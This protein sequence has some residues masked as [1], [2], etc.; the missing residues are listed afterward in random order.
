MA[1]FV[2]SENVVSYLLEHGADVNSRTQRGE[3]PLHY[4]AR[5]AQPGVMR[6]LL[7]NGAELDAKSKARQPSQ[8]S[9]RQLDPSSHFETTP[10][11]DI[12]TDGQTQTQTDTG[13]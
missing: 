12:Q 7:D 1:A 6:L 2:G 3:T 8:F 9:I 10:T 4:A 13:P 11:C 5:A